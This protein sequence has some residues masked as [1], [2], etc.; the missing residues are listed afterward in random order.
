MQAKSWSALKMRWKI[1]LK[2]K[3]NLPNFSAK[4]R[5]HS[6]S[7][8][9]SNPFTSSRQTSRRR[10]KRTRRGESRSEARSS[11]GCR[12]RRSSPSGGPAPSKV[13]PLCPV[14]C[15]G[16]VVSA[17]SSPP[18]CPLTPHLDCPHLGP[19]SRQLGRNINISCTAVS[20]PSDTTIISIFGTHYCT[21]Q[22]KPQLLFRMEHHHPPHALGHFRQN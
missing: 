2:F 9:A 4:I 7:R 1:W 16:T 20:H 14:Q 19:A 10:S 8:N 6:R 5:N 13:A 12:G 17:G 21:A 22:P 18:H 11:G 15:C 3:G